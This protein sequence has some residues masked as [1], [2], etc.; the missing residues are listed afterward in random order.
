M[1]KGT[2][3]CLNSENKTIKLSNVIAAHNTSDNL[4][5]L[6]K[7]AEAGYGVYRDDTELK[8]FN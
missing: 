7:F 1:G 4:L 6:R 2:Y 3:I 8:I 5:S